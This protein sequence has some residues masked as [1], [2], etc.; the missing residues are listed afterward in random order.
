MD[1]LSA[2][3]D[4][5]TATP[6]V[7]VSSLIHERKTDNT[8]KVPSLRKADQPVKRESTNRERRMFVTLTYVLASYLICWFPFYVT[9]DFFAWHSS[10]VPGWL[11]T[12]FFWMTYI[13]STLNPLVYGCTNKDFRIAFKKLIQCKYCR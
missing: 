4:S 1:A 3:Q 13:N 8:L 12:F 6:N 7:S 2:P 9:W 11:Y 5:P 10:L